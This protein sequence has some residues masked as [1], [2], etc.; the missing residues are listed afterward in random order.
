ML[1]RT[2]GVT[3]CEGVSAAAN[4]F[5]GMVE[6]PLFIRPY[7]ARLTRGEL[8]CGIT[9]GMA[10]IAGTVMILYARFL[11]P[12]LGAS[13]LGHVLIASIISA[14]AAIVTAHILMPESEVADSVDVMAIRSEAHGRLGAI[15][16]G[17]TDGVQIAINVCAMLIVAVGLDLP[18]R[19]MPGHSALRG[20]EAA[21]AAARAGVV[22]GAAGLAHRGAV[23]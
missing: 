16:R 9:C 23:G 5:V 22:H 7:L 6:A 12:V 3:G 13:A 2:L 8:F 18:G 15:V 14:P 17:A 1:R 20:G 11:G 21:F 4:V 10:T 19:R